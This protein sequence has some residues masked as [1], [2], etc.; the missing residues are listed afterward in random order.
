MSSNVLTLS[1][2]SESAL[3]ALQVIRRN[4]AVVHFAPEKV[5]VAMTKAF[6]AVEGSQ[7]AVSSRVREVVARLTDVVVRSLTRR[8]PDGGTVHIEDIQDQVELALMRS[9]E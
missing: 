1:A 9:G 3:A 4:G 5:S 2:G 7:S 8:L 6:L